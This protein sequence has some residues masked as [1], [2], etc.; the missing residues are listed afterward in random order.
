MSSNE[1]MLKLL[2]QEEGVKG[3]VAALA[4]ALKNHADEM[5]DMGIKEKVKQSIEV[6]EIL[7]DL[8]WAID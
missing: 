5:S 4:K 6:S 8:S 2:I 1:K 3:A 7:E